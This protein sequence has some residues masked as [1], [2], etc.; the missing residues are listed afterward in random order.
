L[1]ADPIVTAISVVGHLQGRDLSALIIRKEPKGH[2]TGKFVEGPTLPEGSKV[3]VVD[4]VVTTGS[5]LIKSI[6]RLRGEGYRPVQVLAILDREEG[7]RERLE[8]SGYS[9]KSLFTREDLL[10][11]S[12]P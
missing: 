5:S 10:V 11:R 3:A 12:G 2:G 1:G 6:E 9:L 4:D 8:A 7:G